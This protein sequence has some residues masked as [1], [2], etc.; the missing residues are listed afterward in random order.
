MVKRLSLAREPDE[1]LDAMIA[2][3]RQLY[4]ANTFLYLNVRD[5]PPGHFRITR[6]TT[7]AGKDLIR[8]PD[9][10]D[11]EQL[12]VQQGGV[13]SMLLLDHLPKALHDLDLQN[14]PILSTCPEEVRSLMALPIFDQGDLAFW[15]VLL[16]SRPMPFTQVL[17]EQYTLRANLMGAA[18]RAVNAMVKLREATESVQAE[19]DRMAKI[20][21][22]LLPEE[23]PEIPGMEI[24]ASYETFDRVGGDLYDFQTLSMPDAERHCD[25]NK[26]W[27]ILISDA[28]G[29]GPS[30]A[31]VAAM[32]HAILHAYP[33][34]PS[35]PSEILRHANDQLAK[36][37]IES[38]F[39]TAFLMFYDP[40]TR[41]LTYS[42]AGHPP[43]LLKVSLG[44]GPVKELLCDDGI[45]LGIMEGALYSEHTLT[46]EPGQTIVL[47]TDGV[48]DAAN[49]RGEMFE[50][51]GIIKALESCVGD[52]GCV[53]SSLRGA[54]KRHEAG[55]RSRDD[56]T[57]VALH[58]IK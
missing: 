19:V 18:F 46:L 15:V 42:C 10:F 2:G 57:I 38:S 41:Q 11:A 5:L 20:Q 53:I 8:I 3:M 9:P 55:T 44:P 13:L 33:T 22:A 30:A 24:R 29:H 52:A 25:P 40:A 27:A 56:Q 45:P 51:K 49:P 26:P 36:K 16:D 35:G 7:A 43:P 21:E 17:V 4:G 34:V 48:T 6:M 37:R 28:S 58:L 1:V 14:D 12:P 23:M 31:V 50:T 47:Y 54:L 39:I 32:L